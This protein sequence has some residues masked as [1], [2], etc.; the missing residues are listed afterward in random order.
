MNETGQISW[1]NVGVSI[2]TGVSV[3]LA[4]SLALDWLRGDKIWEGK[5]VI[6]SLLGAK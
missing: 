2:L 4:T 6:P 5:G 1:K 3:G